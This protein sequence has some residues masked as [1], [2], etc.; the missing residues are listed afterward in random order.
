MPPPTRNTGV[1]SAALKVGSIG[2]PSRLSRGVVEVE[3]KV[4]SFS[5]AAIAIE[6]AAWPVVT[7]AGF[8]ARYL[9]IHS[10]PYFSTIM[11]NTIKI[12][13]ASCRE[14]VETSGGGR[15]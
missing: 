8:C 6:T 13:R 12:G 11:V 9:S 3:S 4:T 15:V 7:K 5:P 10:Q 14:R 1:G 2:L